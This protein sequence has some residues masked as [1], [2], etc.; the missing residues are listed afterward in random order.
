M[1]QQHTTGSQ[2]TPKPLS[3]EEVQEILD[4]S[5]FISFMGLQV[6]A[7]DVEGGSITMRMPMRPEFERRPGT[8]QF[9]GG[10]IAALIDTVGDYALVMRLGAGDEILLTRHGTPFRCGMPCSRS[11]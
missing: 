5:P 9:H 1:S 10:P 4:A 11:R 3:Q 6:S 2:E 8:G 7:M